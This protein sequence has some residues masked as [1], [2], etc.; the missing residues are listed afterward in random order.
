MFKILV[1]R[2][3]PLSLCLLPACGVSPDRAVSMAPELQVAVFAEEGSLASAA[4]QSRQEKARKREQEKSRQDREKARRAQDRKAREARRRQD[5]ERREIEAK[6]D[7]ARRGDPDWPQGRRVRETQDRDRRDRGRG[8]DRDRDRD[9]A[10]RGSRSGRTYMLFTWAGGDYDFKD[11]RG[12]QDNAAEVF[13]FRTGATNS[14]GTGGGVDIK[15]YDAKHDAYAGTTMSTGLDQLD[16]YPFFTR[17]NGRGRFH[18]TLRIGPYY[19]LLSAEQNATGRYT[20]YNNFGLR[21][22]LEPTL[23]LIQRPGATL[24]AYTTLSAGAHFTY[25][26]DEVTRENYTSQGTVLSVEPGLRLVMKNVVLSASY[27]LNETSIR[28]SSRE[29]NRNGIARELPRVETEFKGFMF[30]FGFRF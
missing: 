19:S 30:T 5:R 22:E 29:R 17:R 6:K 18:N 21:V 8:R 20:S 23:N 28:E 1:T 3:A 12:V 14:R 7:Q 4:P 15:L 13:R 2:I 26:D 9:R 25:I 10:P 16:V 24:Q 27:H 11:G